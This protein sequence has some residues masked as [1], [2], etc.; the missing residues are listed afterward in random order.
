MCGGEWGTIVLG[1]CGE[2]AQSVGLIEASPGVNLNN[3]N[4]FRPNQN[5][6][7]RFGPNF[8]QKNHGRG[9]MRGNNDNRKR[10]NPF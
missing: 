3:H 1:E 7:N 2:S 9:G 10:R 6:P 8:G 5:Q 4:R